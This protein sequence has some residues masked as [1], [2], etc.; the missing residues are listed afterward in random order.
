M[1]KDSARQ[2]VEQCHRQVEELTTNYGDI[3]ILW[4]DGGEDYVVAFSMDFGKRCVP[5]DH[6]QN[7][8]FKD[9]WNEDPLDAMVREKQPNIVTSPRI[10]S[11]KHGDFKVYECKINNFDTSCAWETCDRI[12]GSWGWTPRTQP[13]S[14]RELVKLL[15]RVVT[16]GGNLLLNVGPDALGRIPADAVAILKDAK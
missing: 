8:R 9:F 5:P 3:D 4:Y 13:Q 16:G 11:K 15:I 1:F 2:M 7:P 14:L 6:K 10:G 12:A